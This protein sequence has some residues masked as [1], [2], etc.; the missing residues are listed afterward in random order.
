[1]TKL[2]YFITRK[3]AKNGTIDYYWQCKYSIAEKYKIEKFISLGKDEKQ[4]LIR[5]QEINAKLEYCK[6]TLKETGILPIAEERNIE[7]GTLKHINEIYLNDRRF[8]RL[9]PIT[10]HS[11]IQIHNRL[12]N[13]ILFKEQRQSLATLKIDKIDRVFC[14]TLYDKLLISASVRSAKHYIDALNNLIKT[15]IDYG[16][17]KGENPCSKLVFE[18]NDHRDQVWSKEEFE[19]F[20]KSALEKNYTGLYIAMNLAYYTAQRQTDILTLKWSQISANFESIKIQQS[21]TG[22][23]VEIPI[24]KLKVIRNIL[25]QTEKNNEYVVIDHTDN[26]PYNHRTRLFSDR[27]ETIRKIS[28]IRRELLFRDLRRTSILALDEAG[29]TS[30]EISSISGHSRNSIIAMLEV[31]APKTKQKAGDAID[32]LNIKNLD[33]EK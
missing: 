28:N 4:A 20:C 14:K 32:K 29:C 30:G 5:W 18:K 23:K 1:M 19:I 12:I 9:S 17:L 3:Q 31:Y 26:K 33:Y 27:F 11:Y 22:A 16:Y 10:Q 15:A 13:T 8:K 7:E 21:K 25:S 2:K 6:R 24:D